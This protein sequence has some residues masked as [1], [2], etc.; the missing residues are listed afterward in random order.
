MVRCACGVVFCVC[1]L[2]ESPFGLRE[3][4]LVHIGRPE[5]RLAKCPIHS[6]LVGLRSLDILLAQ[7][8]P[9]TSIQVF[10]ADESFSQGRE[11][12]PP[13]SI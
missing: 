4:N 13:S 10:Y 2:A 1:A 8:W 9:V 12:L 3:V 6:I 7:S 5:V 11:H